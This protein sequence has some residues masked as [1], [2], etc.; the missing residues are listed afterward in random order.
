MYG[1]T[2]E[3]VAAAKGAVVEQSRNHQQGAVGGVVS[4]DLNHPNALAGV[5][6]RSVAECSEAK[7]SNEA[8]AEPRNTRPEGSDSDRRGTPNVVPENLSESEKSLVNIIC[9]GFKDSSAEATKK[10][11]GE[12]RLPVEIIDRCIV[13][14]LDIVGKDF[15][16][17]KK[18]LPQLLLAADTVSASFAVIKAHLE[19]TGNAQES[20][21]SIV[22][23]T[24]F[25]EHTPLRVV[26]ERK[27]FTSRSRGSRTTTSGKTSSR[28][29]SKTTATRSW[30]WGKMFPR[31]KWSRLFWRRT[32]SS[33]G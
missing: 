7:W 24:V 3:Q 22:I 31:K 25:G 9:K 29:C 10:L 20:K 5:E 28:P 14:A 4:S 8:I 2:A 12:G 18:F 26:A 17:G 32:F 6:A 21:G 19:A 33:L 30:I 1:L 23:C 11:L 16:T 15:E 13:P 27:F